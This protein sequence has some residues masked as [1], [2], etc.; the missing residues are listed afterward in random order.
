MEN[1]LFSEAHFVSNV[2]YGDI[3][4]HLKV[5][6][7]VALEYLSKVDAEPNNIYPVRMTD[8]FVHDKRIEPLR[9]FIL[10]S[11]LQVLNQ[12]G[13]DLRN[14]VVNMLDMWCQEH[15]MRSG[16]DYH[17][18]NGAVMSGFYF[19]DCPSE[20]S[21]LIFHDPRSAKVFSSL[22]ELNENNLT[23]ASN[24]INYIPKPG[25]LVF[26]NSWLPHSVLKNTSNKEFRFIH[27]NVGVKY[28]EQCINQPEII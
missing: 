24:I 5:A 25:M 26:A 16:M 28:T 10:N 18:H 11:V 14:G 3:S 22:P 19:I 23:S 15:H 13:Y 7:K 12:Q 6:K 8:N 9:L 21:K 4:S 1:E 20:D 17:V 2:Y 27:F